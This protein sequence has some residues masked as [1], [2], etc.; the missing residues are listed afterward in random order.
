MLDATLNRT[1][2]STAY[3]T[4]DLPPV[5]GDDGAR[6]LSKKEFEARLREIGA[7][8]Y[9]DKHPFHHLLHGGAL[10]KGQLQAWALNRYYYQISIPIKDS[11]LLSRMRSSPLRKI[12]IKR[13][14][15]HDG[16]GEDDGGIMR[17]YRLT[18]GLD[19]SRA[20]VESTAGILPATRFAVDAY[21][22]FVRE[23]SLLEGV[24]S[25]LTELFAPQIHQER[26]AGML[27]NYDFISDDVMAYFKKRLNQATE[28]ADFV[29]AY[30]LEHATRREQQ[31]AVCSA[32][33]FKT[34]VLWV[35]LDA[36]YHAYITGFVP[37]GAFMPEDF[38]ERP[39][40]F[41]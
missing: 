38:N 15:D 8:C 7:R 30:A 40:N 10:N 13:I 20:Y 41:E 29:L 23:R 4:E 28:D 26:I 21:V 2:D 34:D 35:M 18:D 27:A 16:M 32:L 37:Q 31:D 6:P 9:H 12:W 25:S 14:L 39:R 19:L 1:A 17:W 33:R 24:T 3:V 5:K 22:R 36:L 11:A